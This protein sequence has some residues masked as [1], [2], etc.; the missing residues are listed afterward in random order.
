[1]IEPYTAAGSAAGLKTK[2][3]VVR[4]STGRDIIVLTP[5]ADGNIVAAQERVSGLTDFKSQPLDLVENR[6]NGFIYV[7][8]LDQDT[9]E[10]RLTLLRPR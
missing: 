10:G 4:Y 1:V 9:G 8:Q 6:A 7:A 3:L 2:L 5:G